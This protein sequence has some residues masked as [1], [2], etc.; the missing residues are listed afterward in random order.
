MDAEAV[1]FGATGLGA[2]GLGAQCTQYSCMDALHRHSGSGMCMQLEL[3]CAVDYM[4]VRQH[5]GLHAFGE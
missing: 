4:T 1:D 5:L 3:L 2:T